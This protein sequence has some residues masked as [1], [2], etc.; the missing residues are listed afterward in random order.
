MSK[1]K[2]D[3]DDNFEEE[4]QYDEEPEELDE[5][6][7]EDD[8]ED[9]DENSW[10][11]WQKI[12]KENW[13]EYEDFNNQSYELAEI[14]LMIEDKSQMPGAMEKIINFAFER[15]PWVQPASVR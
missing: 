1:R 6:D 9:E 10:K 8:D 7:D 13:E 12:A 11:S 14:E 2:W 4:D 5:D 15:N 3:E